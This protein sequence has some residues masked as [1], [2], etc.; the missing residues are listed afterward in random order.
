MSLWKKLTEYN[1]SPAYPMH[2]PGHKR[3]GEGAFAW[4]G[5]DITEIDGF[6]NLHDAQGILKEAMDRAAKVMGAKR[7]WFVVNGS[8]CGLLA[9]I[10]AITKQG[11]RVLVARNC[12]KAVSHA[13]MLRG[14]QPVWIYPKINSL[15]FPEAITLEQVKC[16][17]AEAQK[18]QPIRAC[19][20][21]SPTYEGVVSP[22]A[23]IADF[24]HEH[25]MLLLVDEAH[26]A[27]LPLAKN[28]AGTSAN[29]Q[30]LGKESVREP[31]KR[32][33]QES[34]NEA[35]Q[36]GKEPIYDT[37]TFPPSAL[38]QD[39][40]IVVQSLHKTL[41][42]PTQTA[43]ISLG[44]ERVAPERVEQ[45]LDIFETSSPSY[46]LMAGM[47]AC[48]EWAEREGAEAMRVYAGRLA[49]FYREAAELTELAAYDASGR[50]P[51]KLLIFDKKFR[52]TGREIYDILK[53]EFAIQPEMSVGCYVLLMT[54]PMDGEEAYERV[55][56]AL[57]AIDRRLA[58][59]PFSREITGLAQDDTGVMKNAD[60]ELCMANVATEAKKERPLF[61][62]EPESHVCTTIPRPETVLPMADALELPYME[63]GVDEL[64]G[65]EICADWV[66]P[67]PPGVPV[68]V[69]GERVG[70]ALAWLQANWDKIKVVIK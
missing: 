53:D 64:T 49:A 23:E 35:A 40:D 47:D 66:T 14:L 20:L 69:P 26:G 42:S 67:Y 39:A 59:E 36:S 9:G 65:D 37:L 6:D 61:S 38:S 30:R 31:G 4:Y 34:E 7:S 32:L 60:H 8:T 25:D 1:D 62:I 27:H 43:I 18:E 24:C 12:H 68:L 57:R 10:F 17:F 44:S 13:L 28:V 55:T 56:E 52:M 5:M 54:S 33:I 41:P 50:D 19:I 15:G 45:F 16:R 51:G 48:M 46:P 70:D 63:R 58:D 3:R 11:D 21:T 2:M 29:M 22:I